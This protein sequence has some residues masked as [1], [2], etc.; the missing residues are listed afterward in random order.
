M[1]TMASPLKE[2]RYK[3]KL[4]PPPK[5]TLSHEEKREQ[6]RD[7]VEHFF[8]P[9]WVGDAKNA[10][11]LEWWLNRIVVGRYVPTALISLPLRFVT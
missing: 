4:P 6:V 1:A 8:D 9:G 5:R 10:E 3:I 2:F 7:M 11:R